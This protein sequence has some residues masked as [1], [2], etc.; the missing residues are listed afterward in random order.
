M[1]FD[2]PNS[3]T[4]GQSYL[5][6]T[7][8]G[9]KWTTTG[10]VTAAVRYDILQ[11]LT[12]AQQNTGRTNIAAAPASAMAG[13]NLIINGF[14]DV[15]QENGTTSIGSL[16][17]DRYVVDQW[18]C[19]TTT[20]PFTAVKQAQ[21]PVRGIDWALGLFN[22]T[23]AFSPAAGDQAITFQAM[24]GQRMAKLG[25][26]AAGGQSLAMGFWLYSHVGGTCIL[27]VRNAAG[28]PR[29]Y[30]VPITIPGGV[31]TYRTAVIPPCPDGTWV[32]DTSNWGY[33]GFCWGC[34]A[35][36]VAPAANVWGANGLVSAPGQT[37]LF[38]T[39]SVGCYVTGMTA[40]PGTVPIPE[41]SSPLMRRDPAD[42]LTTSQRYWCTGQVNYNGYA[43]TYISKFLWWPVAMRAAP[44]VTG[45]N[46]QVS[47]GWTA[48]P[49]FQAATPN[50]CECY[51]TISTPGVG[52]VM[53]SFK[54]SARL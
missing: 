26:G 33:I 13:S 8:D 43:A 39:A 25:W 48:T 52:Y 23:P 2:F 29:A 45:A 34:G 47:G 10:G 6:Y 46:I 24:E 50:G 20:T 42:E 5:N 54:A 37:N 17:T 4:V 14:M 9:E 3:P 12:A 27:S 16:N 18:R 44:S 40:I 30:Q 7:W 32:I 28:T 19:Y 53:D 36:Q 1:A 15:S 49:T 21:V 51:H 31:W 35:N 41:A 22:N 11:G 38:S